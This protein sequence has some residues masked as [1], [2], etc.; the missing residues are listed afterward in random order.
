MK[1]TPGQLKLNSREDDRQLHVH[2]LP[3]GCCY[4]RMSQ[5]IRNVFG[6]RP[7]KWEAQ[8]IDMSRDELEKFT[9]WAIAYL[10]RTK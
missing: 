4:L 8:N 2:E 7:Y 5:R 3:E 6:G 10:A 1:H 9:K